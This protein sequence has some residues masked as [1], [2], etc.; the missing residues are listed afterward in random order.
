MARRL[1][2]GFQAA[3]FQER[4]VIGIPV[5]GVVANISKA[6]T[7]E[8]LSPGLF[9]LLNAGVTKTASVLLPPKELHVVVS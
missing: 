8:C 9:W 4:P 5:L 6:A 2:V 1:A 3:I 7:C